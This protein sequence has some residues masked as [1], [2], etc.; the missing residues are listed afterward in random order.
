[1][2]YKI[3]ERLVAEA[4]F[5]SIRSFMQGCPRV[6]TPLRTHLH[7]VMFGLIAGI[8]GLGTSVAFAALIFSGPLASGFGAGVSTMLASCVILAA[9]VAWRSR[10]PASVAQVQETGIA[11]LAAAVAAATGTMATASSEEK[12]ATAFAILAVST[13][14]TGLLFYLFGRFR[15][16]A[17]VRFLPYSVIAGFLAGSGWL[18]F[19]GALMM[20]A[21]TGGLFAM[22]A[23]LSE[24]QVLFILIPAVLFALAMAAGLRLSSSPLAAPVIMLAAIGL[25]HAALWAGGLPAETARELRW[26]PTVAGA[27]LSLP[28]PLFI[29]GEADWWAVLGVLPVLASL[30]LIAMAGLLLNTGGLEVAA[31]RDIDANAELKVAGQANMLTGLIGGASGFT[32]LGMTLLAGR[33]GVRSRAAGFATAALTALCLP[34][35]TE[36]AAN[37]PL[38]IAA[39]LMMMLGAELLYDWAFAAR[40][41]LPPLEWAVVLAIVL[42]MMTAGFMTGMAV[43]L[44]FSIAAFVYNYARLPVIRLA[45]SGHDRRSSTDRSLAARHILDEKGYLIHTMELQGYL[46]FGTVEQVVKAV[47]QRMLQQPKPRFLVLDFRNVSGTDSAATAGFIKI[48]NLLAA[49]DVDVFLSPLSPDVRRI[50]ERADAAMER[51]GTLSIA[52]DLDHALEACENRI[53]AAHGGAMEPDDIARQLVR[54]L[55]PHPRLPGLVT[56]MERLEIAAGEVLMRAG[57]RASDIFVLGS[58]RVR[59]QI[60]LP[61]GRSLRL[62]SM[63]AGAVLGEVAFYMGGARTADVV[64][65]RKAVLFRL[66]G[67]TLQRL[68][69]EDP[70]LAVLA[71]RLFAITLA[72]RLTLANRMVQLANA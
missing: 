33:L 70:A 58:G 45:A 8:D 17:L 27:G 5:P 61:N 60:T 48:F 69:T 68:E 10:Y 63:T 39:G 28:S 66:T 37:V 59:V 4:S 3:C 34:F 25:F 52:P 2:P 19:E 31:G 42:S 35:A 49:E 41:N 9:L 7:S 38:F 72:E 15:F 6:T 62:R 23:A 26:L 64:I 1:M 50:Y 40:R 56:V 20:I 36:L 12:I 18:L 57:E 53:L 29:I 14:G 51:G 54:V 65:E 67:A 55:G 11:I 44:V 22:L 16:G 21:D 46:F 32:G 43:G 71:H 24:P 47:R 13:V 30:P